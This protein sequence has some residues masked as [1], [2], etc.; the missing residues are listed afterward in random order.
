MDPLRIVCTYKFFAL[1]IPARV[2]LS[3]TKPEEIVQTEGLGLLIPSPTDWL[4]FVNYANLVAAKN[5]KL[6]MEEQLTS[7]GNN[8]EEAQCEFCQGT[9]RAW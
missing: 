6:L 9:A 5:I 3:A 8:V 2:Y 7:L 4:F 1:L